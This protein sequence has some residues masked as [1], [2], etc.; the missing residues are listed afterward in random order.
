MP[1]WSQRRDSDLPFGL[2]RALG[3]AFLNPGLLVSGVAITRRHTLLGI[4]V[5]AMPCPEFIRSLFP[6]SWLSKRMSEGMLGSASLPK[7]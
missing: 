1:S 5:S 6:A 2:G 3:F 7:K 4:V